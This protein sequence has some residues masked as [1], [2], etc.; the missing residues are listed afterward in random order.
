MATA[1]EKRH[2]ERVA[3]L[4]CVICG[5]HGVHVHH[6]RTGQGMSQR[7]SHFLTIPACPECHQGPEGI[8]GNRALLRVR[9]LEELDLLAMTIEAIEN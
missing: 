1:A 9:K 4:P 3:R 6:I 2:L 8:H 5:A 7:S